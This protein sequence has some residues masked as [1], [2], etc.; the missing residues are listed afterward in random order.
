M[1]LEKQHNDL[2]L[3]KQKKI[4]NIQLLRNQYTISLLN[5]GLRE[6]LLNSQEVY[7][8]QIQ[9]MQILKESIRRYTREE[10]SSISSDVAEEILTSILY[11]VDAFLFQLGDPENAINFVKKNN[12]EITYEQGVKIVKDCLEETSA[13][14][15]E[16]RNNKLDV[17]VDSYNI[18]IDESIP[19]F[20][21]KYEVVFDAHNTMASIDYPL[22]IDDMTIQGV[23]YLKQYLTYLK[24]ETEFCQMFNQDDLRDLL[25]NYGRMC[26]FDYRIELFNIFE[27]VLNNAVFSV[28]S[29][30]LPSRIRIS[31]QQYKEIKNLFSNMSDSQIQLIILEAVEKLLHHFNISDSLMSYYIKQ[32]GIN[33]AKRLKSVVKHNRLQ[34]VVIL[35][36]EL[37]TPPLTTFNASDRMSDHRFRL[38]IEKIMNCEKSV[39]KIDIIRT[40]F[41]SL[42]DYIDIL[43]TDCL[44]NDEYEELFKTFGDVELAILTKIVF[45]EELR[46]NSIYLS[47]PNIRKREIESEWQDQFIKFINKIHPS[48]KSVIQQYVYEIDYEEISFY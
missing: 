30:E 3:V 5:V 1:G 32:C 39:D 17:A 8:V 16:I 24:I 25:V 14:F 27:L 9:L 35:E 20:L 21:K 37:K 29:G 11:A 15:K 19:L 28:L 10:S 45:Y 47:S 18:T 7:E 26:G 33:L 48:R 6:G 13:L 43:N 2:L 42:H 34:T 12:M 44:L 40:N 38:L 36:Q 22:A 23:Y 4:N 46:N 41:H 31:V